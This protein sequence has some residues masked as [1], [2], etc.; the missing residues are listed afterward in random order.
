MKEICS[1]RILNHKLLN[2]LPMKENV[3]KKDCG[4]RRYLEGSTPANTSEKSENHGKEGP[5]DTTVGKSGFS[6]FDSISITTCYD[7]CR[8]KP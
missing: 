4:S 1:L 2:D 7:L 5:I 3:K 6:F 8:S